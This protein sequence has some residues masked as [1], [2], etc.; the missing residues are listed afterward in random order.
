MT[1]K[2]GGKPSTMR[3]AIKSVDG[4]R[5]DFVL[6]ATGFNNHSADAALCRATKAQGIPYVR[7]QKGRP[8]AT[9]RALG[10]AFNLTAQGNGA[11]EANVAHVG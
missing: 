1:L 5:Y 8:A 10:R 6:M 11:D 4:D 3:A 2:D 9:I 7:V